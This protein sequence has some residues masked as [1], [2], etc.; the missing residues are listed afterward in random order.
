MK[1]PLDRITEAYFGELG[2][3]F[4]DKVRNRI[5]W[6]C[7]NA[8]GENILDVGCSQGITSILLGREGKNVIGID[9]LEESIQYANNLLSTEEEITKKYVQF[10]AANFIDFAQEKQTFDSIIFGE[11]LEHITDPKR[12][13]KMALNML[14][15]NGSLIITLPFGINDYFDHKKTYYL[16]DLLKF[17]DENIVIEEIKFFGK[18]I[19][20]I[21]K[22]TETSVNTLEINENL[23]ERL[24][25]TF[26]DIERASITLL[27]NKDQLIAEL[28]ENISLA[29]TEKEMCIAKSV[30]DLNVKTQEIS[31]IKEELGKKDLELL[32]KAAEVNNLG[33]ELGKKDLEIVKKDSEIF[34]LNE[35]LYKINQ[36]LKEKNESTSVLDHDYELKQ[37]NQDLQDRNRHLEASYK[38]VKQQLEESRK[39]LKDVNAKLDSKD[40]ELKKSKANE[41][42]LNSLLMEVKKQATIFKKEKI[43]VQEDLLESYGKE[44]KLLKAHRTLMRR[45]KALSES[46]LGKFTLL[47]WGK[48]RQVFGGK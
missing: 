19:G 5:H 9:L 6:I 27:K 26:Y 46:K 21:V 16:N 8:V 36:L 35:E 10:K 24:E 31:I 42:K 15:P 32:N 29:I 47:Y 11:I 45:Y 13:I 40:K 48:R 43:K 38:K 12:F 17:Q 18:W 4:A 34:L 14:N 33:E 25:N 7:E 3:T 39:K 28:E 20:A 44:E 22:R 2:E 1:K 23:L 30:A 41:K 37:K